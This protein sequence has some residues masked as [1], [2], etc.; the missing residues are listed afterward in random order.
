MVNKQLKVVQTGST[1]RE[2][3]VTV[4]FMGQY[5]HTIDAKGRIF[6]PAKFRETLGEHFVVTVGLDGC[7]F[8]YPDEKW[9][10]FAVQLKA[11]PGTKEARQLQRYFLAGAADIEIDKQGRILI[12]PHLR[13]QGA[14]EKDV[15]FVGVLDKIELWSSGRWQ[16]NRFGN[17]DDAAERAAAQGLV[18]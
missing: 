4:M 9:E 16:E 2:R 10:E 11:L 6:V 8:L 17:M 5:N 14:L 15:I 13:E 3:Q 12:P 1:V 7:L 18:F